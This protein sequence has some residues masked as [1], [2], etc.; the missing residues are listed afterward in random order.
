M[1]LDSRAIQIH[2]DG[3]CYMERDRVSVC[4]AFV[5][6]PEHLCLPEFQIVDYG[7]K[8]NTNI[9]MELTAC[10]KGLEWALENEPWQD[11]TRIYVVTDLQFLANNRN[12]IQYWKKNDWRYSSGEPVDH[13]DLW[14]AILKHINKLSR[15]GLRVDF[16]YKKGKKDAM[17]KKVDKAAK[18]A[19]QR[20]GFDHDFG[21]RPGSYTRSM[22]PGG[23]A[24]TPFHASGQTL[25]I[26]PYKKKPYPKREEKVSFHIFDETTQLYS[27]KFYAFAEPNLSVDLHKGNGHKVLFN[28][29]PK[30]PQILE[31]IGD[32]QLPKPTRKR[33]TKAAPAN[34]DAPSGGGGVP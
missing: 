2:T 18:T 10:A 6:Y 27:G 11:V 19:A 17:G 20:G 14:D 9:R 33:K 16:Y 15:V 3:S 34:H 25:V 30:F 24:A 32:V 28:A 7:S 4:A 22:V 31:K 12:N 5:V 13:H 21:F 8:E 29:N 26:R 1:S 23:A